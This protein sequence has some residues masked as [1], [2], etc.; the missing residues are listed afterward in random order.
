MWPQSNYTRSLSLIH[1]RPIQVPILVLILLPQVLVVTC[2]VTFRLRLLGLRSFFRFKSSAEA[3]NNAILENLEANYD[4]NARAYAPSQNKRT[5]RKSFALIRTALAP[6]GRIVVLNSRFVTTSKR[7]RESI[8]EAGIEESIAS[9]RSRFGGNS[10]SLFDCR[11]G[12]FRSFSFFYRVK[13]RRRL[14]ASFRLFRERICVGETVFRIREDP[15]GDSRYCS[16]W[17]LLWASSRN[18]TAESLIS[19]GVISRFGVR[20]T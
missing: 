1:S 6:S 4:K 13:T 5:I 9:L 15:V 11:K 2:G 20:T 18:L 16:N 3:T 7:L 19:S 17:N 14:V 8:G 12:E 10:T